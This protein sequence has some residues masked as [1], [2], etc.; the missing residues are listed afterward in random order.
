MLKDVCVDGETSQKSNGEY[1]LVYRLDAPFHDKRC[2][3]HRGGCDR[4]RNEIRQSRFNGQQARW[5]RVLHERFRRGRTEVLSMRSIG[6]WSI[7]RT[8]GP[9]Q[10]DELKA[11]RKP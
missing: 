6:P 11:S 10:S 9:H 5:T 8:C 3:S 7:P 2:P 4:Q 1:R